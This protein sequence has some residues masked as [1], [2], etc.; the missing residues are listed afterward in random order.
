MEAFR[1]TADDTTTARVGPTAREAAGAGPQAALV[2]FDRREARVVVL[3]EGESAVVGRSFPADVQLAS[4]TLSRQHAR[5]SLRDAQLQ[6]TDLDSRN[7]VVVRGE[8]VRHAAL[9][10]GDVAW[11]G[12]VRL[13]VDS[14]GAPT[15]ADGVI[16]FERFHGALAQEMVRA[17]EYRR[18]LSLMLLRRPGR[19]PAIADYA[20]ALRALLRPTESLAIY[21]AATVAV[22]LPESAQD[23]AERF[24][25]RVRERVDGKLVA[26]LAVF[27]GSANSDEALLTAVRHAVCRAEKDGPLVVAAAAHEDREAIADGVVLVRGSATARVHDLAR[28]A[29]RSRLPIL[30]LGETGTGKELLARDVHRASPRCDGPLRVV[31]CGALP[32]SLMESVLFGH[33]K[34]AFTGATAAQPG[35]FEQADGGTL[36]LDEVG[37]LSPSAQAALLRVLETGLVQRLGA[38]SERRVDVRLLSA[39]HRD[40]TEMC[41]Q[42]GFREDLLHR[43]NAVSLTLPPLRDRREEVRPLAELFLRQLS[44]RDPVL[45]TEG[46]RSIHADAM[47][48]L[49]RFAWPGNV[50][51]LRNAIERA[52]VLALGEAIELEDLP[53]ELRRTDAPLPTTAPPA[54]SLETT[55]S[56][57]SATPFNERLA[58]FE[59]DLIRRALA[60]AGGQRNR[61]AELLKMPLRTFMKRLKQY[62]LG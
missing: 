3:G 35:V 57:T 12:E 42:Q 59:A 46:P 5:L 36:F 62:D 37:E 51:Q 47:A 28:R 16:T 23:S 2:L 24:F 17:R 45:S 13:T 52:A 33:A 50:R 10:A 56:V 27:P 21:G 54:P 34:G 55:G 7:G 53:E 38:T 22:L 32:P 39:T 49:E 58:A 44:E 20:P 8:R 31:N 6:I 61:A 4:R 41:R 14:A 26:G 9:H 15:N 43:L 11:L 25:E 29:A 60:E 1:H 19:E 18:P 48:R 40:L 30:I